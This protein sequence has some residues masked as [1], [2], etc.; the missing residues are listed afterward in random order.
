L[1][2]YGLVIG[3]VFLSADI[4]GLDLMLA[5]DVAVLYSVVVLLGLMW[6]GNSYISGM[7]G[8]VPPRAFP[9]RYLDRDL[10]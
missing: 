2:D 3:G 6:P 9:A 4:F 5:A 10:R 1:S 7:G 8:S